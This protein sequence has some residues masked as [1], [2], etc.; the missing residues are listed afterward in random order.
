MQE[1]GHRGVLLHGVTLIQHPSRN[2]KFWLCTPDNPEKCKGERGGRE[3]ERERVRL[4]VE[5]W[6][7]ESIGMFTSYAGLPDGRQVL[8]RHQSKRYVSACIPFGVPSPTCL[9]Y[10]CD[11]PAQNWPVAFS[12]TM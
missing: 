4:R 9:R 5:H 1:I 10:S 2:S 6:Q 11:L 3:R 7:P 12:S 8:Q